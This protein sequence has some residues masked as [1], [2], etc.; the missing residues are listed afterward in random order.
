MAH[1]NCSDLAPGLRLEGQF[2][3]TLNA[4]RNH[5]LLNV[6]GIGSWAFFKALPSRP[7]GG[8]KVRIQRPDGSTLPATLYK[9]KG[10]RKN[11][12]PRYAVLWLHGGGYAI[13]APNM[14]KLAL[15]QKILDRFNCILLAPDYTLSWKAPYPAAIHDCYTALLWLKDHAAMYGVTEEK[16]IVGGESAGG[17]LTAALTLY[18][19]DHGFR[20]IGLQIPLYP[21]LDCLPTETNQ[22]NDAPNWNST[23]NDLAWAMY[24]GD[25]SPADA[26]KYASP[27]RET[28]YTGLPPAVSFV[29]SV[30]PF[31]REDVTY[32]QNLEAA[33]VPVRFRVFDRCFHAFDMMQ[34]FAKV[35]RE[36]TQWSLTAIEEL[37]KEL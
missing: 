16:L 12:G 28:D 9:G 37:L 11:D 36:A 18:A 1:V 35:S 14:I 15:A 6:V 5:T 8:E 33:G 10:Y 19:R 4:F 26:E 25:T 32:F 21:M 20:D 34:P 30:E 29:G 2:L 31:Y 24:L 13:G 27:A 7:L 17:G 22:N 3:Q 23:N